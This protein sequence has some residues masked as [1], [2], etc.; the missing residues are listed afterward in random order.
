MCKWN[1]GKLAEALLNFI[2]QDQ[3]API[4]ETY[5]DLYTNF[6]MDKM[7]KKVIESMTEISYDLS[8]KD[9][10]AEPHYELETLLKFSI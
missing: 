4:L 1:L 10:D 2:P 7:R 5:D 6:Y 8:L 3:A 9:V